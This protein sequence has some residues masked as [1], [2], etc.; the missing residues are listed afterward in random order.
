MEIHEM[1]NLELQRNYASLLIEI[2]NKYKLKKE[3]EQEM[4]ERMRN[5]KLTN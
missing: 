3:M 2:E 1:T 5:G 4:I